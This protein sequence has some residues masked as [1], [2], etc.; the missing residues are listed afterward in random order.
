[1]IVKFKSFEKYVAKH[2]KSMNSSNKN[3]VLCIRQAEHINRAQLSNEINE[4]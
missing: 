2:S 1:M 3:D 4:I